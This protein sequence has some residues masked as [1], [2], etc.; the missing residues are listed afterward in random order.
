MR[1]III[2]VFIAKEKLSLLALSFGSLLLSRLL[3]RIRFCNRSPTFSLQALSGLKSLK[4]RFP[5]LL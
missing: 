5:R 3:E 2:N 1:D 4:R